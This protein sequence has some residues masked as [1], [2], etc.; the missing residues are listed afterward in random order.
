MK[1]IADARQHSL[2]LLGHRQSSPALLIV[3]KR[4]FDTAQKDT[5][6][7]GRLREAFS[8]IQGL[9]QNDAYHWMLASL[10]GKESIW[11]AESYKVTMISPATTTVRFSTTSQGPRIVL[12][13]PYARSGSTFA[14]IRR[15]MCE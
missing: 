2:V 9:G 8:E 13:A 3:E 4:A 7:F 12:K 14:N 5:Y 15:R 11:P 10:Q 1:C 6:D